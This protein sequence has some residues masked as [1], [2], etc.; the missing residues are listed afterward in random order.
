MK[1]SILYSII[2]FAMAKTVIANDSMKPPVKYNS[3]HTNLRRQAKSSKSTKSAKSAK[4]V[5]LQVCHK[6]GN[7]NEGCGWMD[8]EV[9][10][11]ALPGHLGHGDY[12]GTCSSTLCNDQDMCTQD[13]FNITNCC[14]HEPVICA[15]GEVCDTT[16]GCLNPQLLCDDGDLCTIE[17]WDEGNHQCQNNPIDCSIISRFHSCDGRTGTCEA[18]CPDDGN[19]CT[20]EGWNSTLNDCYTPLVCP[21]GELCEP[22]SGCFDVG[23]LCDDQD[24]CTEE[25]WDIINRECVYTNVTCPLPDQICDSAQG[26]VCDDGD[27]CT[28]DSFDSS[29]NI[30][31]FTEIMCLPDFS[32]D[33]LDGVCKEDEELVPCV[34]VIDEDSNMNSLNRSAVWLDFRNMW[35]SRPFCLLVPSPSALGVVS[36]PPEALADPNFINQTVTRDDGSGTPSD[37]FNICG[38][39]SLGS[40][41]VPFV[42]LF[43]DGSGSMDKSTVKNA[44]NKFIADATNSGFDLCE[45]YNGNENWIL[46]FMTTL[47]PNST[48]NCTD[49]EPI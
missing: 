40:P 21:P 10:A 20:V 32:C 34:A 15:T 7:A 48:S 16:I 14:T 11:N 18:T 29:S 9:D 12:N 5:K 19:A 22:T 27:L 4:S 46:P 42:G 13:Y 44:Y 3:E 37:W 8:L 35:P 2:G 49:P 31:T 33:P 36:I 26:C 41:N 17:S 1:T 38:L 28:I 6:T 43:V 30:C 24:L 25:S 47:T 23:A 39:G 45:V